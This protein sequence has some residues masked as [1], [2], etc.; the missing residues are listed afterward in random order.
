MK[1]VFISLLVLSAVFSVSC[2]DSNPTDRANAFS[3][4]PKT[5]EDSLVHEVLE[6]HDVAMAKMM[7]L[8]KSL[9]RVDQML[10]SV[11]KIPAAKQNREYNAALQQLKEKL[12]YAEMAMN[13]WMDEFKLDTLKDHSDLRITYLQ[14]EK[15]KVN[16]MREAVLSSLVL[17]DSL[18]LRK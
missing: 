5:L 9:T 16:K 12:T 18:L 4:K 8:S 15:T 2:A 10:D 17:A 11:N 3:E 7:K 1:S 6:G 13:T 14:N